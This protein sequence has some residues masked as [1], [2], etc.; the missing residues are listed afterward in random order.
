MSRMLY[1]C[2]S[3]VWVGYGWIYT[4]YTSVWVGWDNWELERI[5]KKGLFL[6]PETFNGFLMDIVPPRVFEVMVHNEHYC[7]DVSGDVWR[8]VGHSC[9]CDRNLGEWMRMDILAEKK[10]FQT[11]VQSWCFDGFGT[12]SA[13]KHLP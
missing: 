13:K 7:L 12:A 9:Q 5:G 4:T 1:T 10:L 11:P 6:F 3:E 8:A 2:F